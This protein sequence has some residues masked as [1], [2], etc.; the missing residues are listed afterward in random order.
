VIEA[1]RI[2]V[3]KG[4]Y[5]NLEETL[6]Y[7]L[8]ARGK[9]HSYIQSDTLSIDIDKKG[10]L[11]NVEISIPKDKWAIDEAMTLPKKAPP[12]N[13]RF[14]D[15]RLNIAGESYITNAGKNCLRIRFSADSQVRTYEIAKDLLADVN[16][17]SELAGLWILNISDDY[18]FKGE[19]AFRKGAKPDAGKQ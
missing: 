19:M 13:I 10:F 8:R 17:V 12:S 11:L 7:A 18:G 15:Y 3:G 6:N 2:P 16:L 9:F 1:V 4:F 5:D 14:L